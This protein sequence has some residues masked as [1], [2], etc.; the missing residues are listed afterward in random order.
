MG[1]MIDG[2]RAVGDA[3]KHIREERRKLA[4][5]DFE[6]AQR[7]A[8]SLGLTLQQFSDTHYR[9]RTS[10]FFWDIH[11]GNQRIRRSS[12]SCPL[13]RYSGDW[14]LITIVRNAHEAIQR[15]ISRSLTKGTDNGEENRTQ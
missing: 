2:L 10:Q 15:M 6:E 14:T 1:D 8:D 9:I 5:K 7:I 4:L 3:T 11:P 13:I 12:P